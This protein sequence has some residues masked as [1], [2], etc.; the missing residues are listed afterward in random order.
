MKDFWYWEPEYNPATDILTAKKILLVK[1]EKDVLTHKFNL[2]D[3]GLENIN[4]YDELLKHFGGEPN[5]TYE[6]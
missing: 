2:T 1:N 5:M 6:M 4:S 3:M